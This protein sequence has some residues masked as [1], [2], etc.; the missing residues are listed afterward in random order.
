MLI[1]EPQHRESM[2]QKGN[3]IID[4]SGAETLRG[5]T[6]AESIF[7]FEFEAGGGINAG[8]GVVM[9]YNHLIVRHHAAKIL[10]KAQSMSTGEKAGSAN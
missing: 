8:L 5:L 2:L 7:I 4:E 9:I 10:H 1:L 3:L 6:V